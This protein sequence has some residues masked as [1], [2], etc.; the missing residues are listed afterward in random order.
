MFG[1]TIMEVSLAL[2]VL[3]F[4]ALVINAMVLGKAL[5]L[6]DDIHESMNMFLHGIVAIESMDKMSKLAQDEVKKLFEDE[7]P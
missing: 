3:M 6:I 2:T 1:I 5:E 7:W 4:I